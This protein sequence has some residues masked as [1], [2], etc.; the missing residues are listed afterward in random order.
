MAQ[1]KVTFI[2]IATNFQVTGGLGMLLSF[3]GLTSCVA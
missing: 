1:G 2:G 3:V